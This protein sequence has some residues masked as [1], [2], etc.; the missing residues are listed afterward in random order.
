MG[1]NPFREGSAPERGELINYVARCHYFI[2]KMFDQVRP[3]NTHR[4]YGNFGTP[5]V[6]APG[7]GTK[8]MHEIQCSVNEISCRQSRV[9]L[10]VFECGGDERRFYLFIIPS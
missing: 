8:G 2:D 3:L 7:R 1:I 9:R 4:D 6:K 10:P 5:E